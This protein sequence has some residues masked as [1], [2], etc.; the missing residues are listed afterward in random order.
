[1]GIDSHRINS[2]LFNQLKWHDDCLPKFDKPVLIYYTDSFTK[3]GTAHVAVAALRKCSY[4]WRGNAYQLR[5]YIIQHTG[6]NGNMLM[7]SPAKQFSGHVIAWAEPIT[8]T[9]NHFSDCCG[10][11]AIIQNAEAQLN[12]EHADLI[13]ELSSKGKSNETT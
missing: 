8:Y 3:N 13:A 1:M 11:D 7:H 4:L 10:L 6:K 9:A 12:K 5:W 2:Q